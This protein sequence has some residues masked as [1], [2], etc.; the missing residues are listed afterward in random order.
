MRR[1]YEFLGFA[2]SVAV[3]AAAGCASSREAAWET[4]EAG[5]EAK[6]A[7]AQSQIEQLA[8][9]AEAA[10][11]QRD[12]QQQLR[13]AI[14]KWEQAVEIDPSKY[15]LWTS[16]ARA[17]YFLADCHLRFDEAQA[18]AM[19]TVYED[20]TKAAEQALMQVSPAFREKMQGGARME[21]AVSLLDARAVGALYWRSSAL[22]K[23]ASE[24]G[25]ATLLSYKD[26]IRKVMT[27]VLE[28]DPTFYFGGPH[29]YFG[30]FYAR[31]PG[32]A[33]GDLDRSK[34]HFEKSLEMEPNYFATRV[35][36]A[37]DWAVKAQ[38]RQVFDEQLE[39]VLDG[40]PESLPPVAPEN[41]CEQ[42]KAER[43]QEKA[44]ELFE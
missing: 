22:G 27:H 11:E 42:K 44:F 15:E 29:R 26:E 18:D 19:M 35:L 37:E 12:D 14:E 4:T 32:F 5:T 33:G 24:K 10:W 34:R 13:T 39:Y 31:A 38:D 23:W 3:V 2:A 20:S 1:L 25:F 6:T 43:L 30:A 16:L 41:R 17:R 8:S 21:D 9:D 28:L 36:Y 40:D 7:E